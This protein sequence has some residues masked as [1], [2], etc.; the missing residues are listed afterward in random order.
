MRPPWVGLSGYGVMSWNLTPASA[1]AGHL[2]PRRS[3]AL[4]RM[5]VSRVVSLGSNLLSC[6][7]SVAAASFSRAPEEPGDGGADTH[8]LLSALAISSWILDVASM[9]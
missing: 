2:D 8:H 5:P 7:P 4:P 6:H 3:P 1:T 9:L